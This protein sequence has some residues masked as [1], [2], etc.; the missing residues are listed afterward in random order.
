[1]I[2]TPVSVTVLMSIGTAAAIIALFI[3][4]TMPR[5]K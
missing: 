5:I 1:M 3:L 2:L 4:L